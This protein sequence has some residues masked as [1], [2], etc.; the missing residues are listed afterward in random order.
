MEREQ[1]DWPGYRILF[2][3]AALALVSL[4]RVP[5]YLE[6]VYPRGRYNDFLQDYSGP[7][8]NPN[9]FFVF[10]FTDADLGGSK[11]VPQNI[12]SPFDR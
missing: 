12:D 6:A 11:L 7:G 10:G 4:W 3:G 2:W 1:A 5:F 8:T 9:Q